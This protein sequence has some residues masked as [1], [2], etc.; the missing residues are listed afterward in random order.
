MYSQ[1]SVTDHT[2]GEF[3]P[4]AHLGGESVLQCRNVQGLG[5]DEA[6]FNVR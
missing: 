2:R 1:N 4:D 5:L 6:S 3:M